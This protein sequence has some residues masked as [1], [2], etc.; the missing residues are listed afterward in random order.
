MSVQHAA[1][2][3]AFLHEPKGVSTATAGQRYIANG[4]GSGSWTDETLAPANTVYINALADF[5]APSG[6]AITL[7]ADTN[8]IIGAAITTSDRFILA[9]NNSI[10]AFNINSPTLTYSGSG[11]MFTG[12]D[13]SFDIHDLRLD[14]ASG[15]VFDLSETGGGDTK[16]FTMTTV[17][18]SNCAKFGTF[19]NMLSID[20]TNSNCTNAD[21]GITLVGIGWL[22]CSFSKFA[23]ISTDVAFIGIDFG[24]S[25]QQNVELTNL[26]L[27][28]PSGAIGLKGLASSG[29]IAANNLATCT[30]SSFLGALAPLNTITNEDIR[31]EFQG[32]AGVDNSTKAADAYLSTT[33]TVTIGSSAVFTAIGST[34]FL[35]DNDARFTVS[36]AGVITYD[37]ESDAC[38]V[39]TITATIDKVA[40][41]ADILAMRVAKNG[42]SIAKS[43]SQ[44][45]SADP[46]SVVS[47]AIISLT[48]NDTIEAMV[49]NN[50][51]SG[52]IDAFDMN[53]SITLSG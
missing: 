44:T 15:T 13:V 3:E 21:D 18:V 53:I 34:N 5:P 35:S 52:D 29:N 39:V 7:V 20:V 2:A 32:N 26:V 43:Q 14:C 30:D 50:D 12:V 6:G 36:T 28:G 49:A 51:T 19:T 47:H 1:I 31:W 23:L 16:V 46:T 10:T 4:A 40:G 33:T 42:T 41:G 17:G 48:K 9:A 8:Y 11:V 37:S 27:V 22:V 24:T 45:Q 25:V 38:F